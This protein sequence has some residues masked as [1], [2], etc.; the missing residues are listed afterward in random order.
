MTMGLKP[1]SNSKL[2]LKVWA[3]TRITSLSL[4]SMV[5]S[6]LMEKA[7]SALVMTRITKSITI[8]VWALCRTEASQM[9]Q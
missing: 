9:T 4:Q 6:H 5:R 8:S 2:M 7:R 3:R 1:S